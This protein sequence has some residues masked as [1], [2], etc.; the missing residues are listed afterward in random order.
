MHLGAKFYTKFYLLEVCVH[1]LQCVKLVPALNSTIK[2][3]SRARVHNVQL[4]KAV[5]NHALLCAYIMT[6]QFWKSRHKLLDSCTANTKTASQTRE[7][8]AISARGATASNF[9]KSVGQVQ[10]ILALP[11]EA[12]SHLRSEQIIDAHRNL[13][14]SSPIS[15]LLTDEPP[16]WRS[17]GK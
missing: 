7:E 17:Q 6:I 2:D 15:L 4:R 5:L 1:G 10:C 12:E 11:S 14:A 8:L 9:G 16:C 13:V 3:R